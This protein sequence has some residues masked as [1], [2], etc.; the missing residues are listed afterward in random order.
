VF[1]QALAD[2]NGDDL[3]DLAMANGDMV[4]LMLGSP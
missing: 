3:L 1:P 4:V 2:F